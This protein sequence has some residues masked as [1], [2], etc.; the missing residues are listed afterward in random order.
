MLKEN[1]RFISRLERIGDAALIL[2][3]FVVAYYGRDSMMFWNQ[4]YRLD[5]PFDG[6]VLAPIQDY[7]FILVV[8]VVAYMV[9]LHLMGAYSSMRLSSSFRLVRISFLSSFFVFLILSSTLFL[10][11]L[12][13][14]RSFVILFCTLVALTLA[15]ERFMVLRVLRPR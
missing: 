14:S 10:L 13:L 3:S 7:A 8:A 6:P 11:K 15:A 5:L 1:W 9:T 12:D 4:Y 2:F